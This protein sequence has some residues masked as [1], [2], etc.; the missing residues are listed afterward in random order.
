MAKQATIYDVAALAGVAPSTVSRTFSRPGRVNAETAARVREVAAELGYRTNRIAQ[1]LTTARTGV[2]ALTVS[3]IGN[4]YYLEIIRGAEAAASAA[5]C[6]MLLSDSRESARHEQQVLERTLPLVDG[7]VLAGSRMSDTAIRA[8]ARQRPVVVL[9]RVVTDLPS[10]APDHALGA[11]SALEHLAGLGHRRVA[12]LA[13]PEASWADGMRWRSVLETGQQ[14]GVKVT[15]LGPYPPTVAGG[16]RA[17][18]ELPAATGAVVAYND[19]VAIGLVRGIQQRGGRVPDDV[20]VVGF[21][22]IFAADLVLP[23]L[24]TVAAPAREMG[25]R[26]V[27]TL[28]SREGRTYERAMVLP[29][30]LVVRGSTA[31]PRRKSTSPA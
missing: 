23:G 8:A 29:T 11:R 7:L 25:A 31:P 6:T 16:S 27:E 3:D 1:A 10:I 28:V 20:S 14:L 19:Q 13:G 26:A 2:V 5:G 21:D 24:T 12:Y 30:R 22:N 18:Q 15:R 9:N 17:A 4:P